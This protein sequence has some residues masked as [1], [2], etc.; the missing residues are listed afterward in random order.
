MPH[1]ARASM[2]ARRLSVVNQ[3]GGVGKTT[4]AVNL[5]AVL[6]GRGYRVLLVDYDPQ[7]NASQFLGFV[8]RLEDPGVYTSADLTV[9]GGRFASLSTAVRRLELLP[10]NDRL[11]HIE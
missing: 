8:D 3:K 11:A 6:A 5:G 2:T 7:G 10:A 9:S 4:T 1:G